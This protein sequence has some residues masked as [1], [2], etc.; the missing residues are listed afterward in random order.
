MAVQSFNKDE[1]FLD[2]L[3]RRDYALATDMKLR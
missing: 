2:R 3:R 1:S